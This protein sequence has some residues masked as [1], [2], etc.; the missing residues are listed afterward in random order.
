MMAL[1]DAERLA[2]LAEAKLKRSAS[3]RAAAETRRLNDGSESRNGA[4]STRSSAS[5]SAGMAKYRAI[6]DNYATRMG[7]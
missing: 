4:R 5:R 1:L 7:W 3:A 2:R 6:R